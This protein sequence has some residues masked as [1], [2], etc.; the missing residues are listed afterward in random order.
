MLITSRD[1]VLACHRGLLAKG[2]P[3]RSHFNKTPEL[4]NAPHAYTGRRPALATFGIFLQEAHQSNPRRLEACRPGLGTTTRGGGLIDHRPPAQA[5]A[6]L[7][8]AHAWKGCIRP[9]PY[10]GFESAPLRQQS[11][12]FRN[13]RFGFELPPQMAAVYGA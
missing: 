13:L 10:R 12:S 4:A 11:L 7:L 9:K 8:K 1:P 3:C 2:Q 6:E 5:V